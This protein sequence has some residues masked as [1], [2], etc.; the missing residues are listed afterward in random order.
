[1]RV[2]LGLSVNVPFKRAM[3]HCDNLVLVHE[4]SG[5][6]QRGRS[7]IETSVNRAIV[8]IA[9]ASWQAVVQD[10][11]RFLLDSSMPTPTD[12]NY[13]LAKLIRSQVMGHSTPSRRRTQRPPGNCFSQLGSTRVPTGHGRMERLD[14]VRLCTNPRT[15][16]LDCATGCEYDTPL[17]TV[18]RNCPRYKQFQ[19]FGW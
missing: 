12:P 9:I 3:E 17:P 14:G 10:M 13:G 1:M 4:R 6:G 5:T 2:V 11:T 7:R 8:V 18:T 16:K 19:L 15:S